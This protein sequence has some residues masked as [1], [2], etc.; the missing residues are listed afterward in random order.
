MFAFFLIAIAVLTEIRRF[1]DVALD[2]L[3][4]VVAIQLGRAQPFFFG[5]VLGFLAKQRLPNGSRRVGYVFTVHR[6]HAGT[7]ALRVARPSTSTL[8]IGTS[9]VR[10][11]RVT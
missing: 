1:I 9:A 5:G 4:V 2:S 8:G 7:Y 6:K 10:T 11:I 3:A